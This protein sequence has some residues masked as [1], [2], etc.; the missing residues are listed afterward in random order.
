MKKS[1]S[2]ASKAVKST[3]VSTVTTTSKS[4]KKRPSLITPTKESTAATTTK[5][6]L[7]DLNKE[8]DDIYTTLSAQKTGVEEPF[9]ETKIDLLNDRVDSILEEVRRTQKTLYADEDDPSTDEILKE[10]T[11]YME[12]SIDELSVNSG[13]DEMD[14]TGVL[15]VDNDNDG[16]AS[17]NSDVYNRQSFGSEA[18]H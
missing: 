18:S 7:D 12:G 4:D 14:M 6:T 13:L 3:K 1:S 5:T 11:T 2:K 15:D 16:L 17:K 9:E 8:L 10:L